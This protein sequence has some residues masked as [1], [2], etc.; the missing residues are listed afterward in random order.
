M[1]QLLYKYFALNH[2]LYLPGI[3]TFTTLEKP[4]VLDFT[5]KTICVESSE[6]IYK[7]EAANA[8]KR[9]FNFLCAQFHTEEWKAIITFNDFVAHIKNVLTHEG[10]F[11]LEGMG[12]ITQKQ[13]GE[14]QFSQIDSTNLFPSV[15]AERVI[16]KNTEH[17]LIVGVQEKTSVEMQHQIELQTEEDAAIVTKEKWWISAIILAVIGVAALAYYYAVINK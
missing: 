14:Y 2:R 4:A 8:D 11:T 17:T 9:F 1:N 16:R 6:I 5:N 13:V 12:I 15:H 10:S 7:N 3:G